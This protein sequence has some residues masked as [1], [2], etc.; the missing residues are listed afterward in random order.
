MTIPEQQL[1]KWSHHGSQEP[2]KRTHEAIR[3]ALNAHEW[4]QGMRYDFYLQGSYRNDTNISGDSDVDV[5]LE[6]KSAFNHDA[7]SLSKHER[8]VLSASFSQA[9]YGWDDFR[10]EALLA[11]ENWFG[12]SLVTQGNKS[13]KLKAKP[14]RLA[15]DIVVCLEHRRYASYHSYVTGIEFWA[16]R[17]KRW[18]INYPKKHYENGT[19]KSARTSD[20]YKRTVR[21]FKNARNHLESTNRISPGL[22]PS[23]FVE[24]L[25]YNAPDSAFQYSFE[26]TYLAI[27]DW[28]TRADLESLSCQN[29]Q[30]NLFGSSPEQW[31]LADA[32]VFALRLVE[33]WI[34]WS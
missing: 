31:S 22:A 8:E 2:S 32:Q 5:V 20:R 18:V 19:A 27:V 13:I 6:L 12:K 4:P 16:L 3:S 29:G 10:R 34:G 24:C 7:P 30:Q 25:L 1:S 14:P 28:M 9:T 26:D 21:M 33:L 23:Y 11:L 15:A 17:D